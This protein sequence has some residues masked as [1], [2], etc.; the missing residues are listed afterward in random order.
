M[1]KEYIEYLHNSGKMPDRYYNQLNGKSA[2][3]NY[4]AYKI[5]QRKQIAER[6]EQQAEINAQIE[7]D[8]PPLVEKA[9]SEIFAGFDK[10]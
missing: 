9:L 7:Q 10:N 5:K 2:Q 3:E 6:R 4:N 1:N 8:L